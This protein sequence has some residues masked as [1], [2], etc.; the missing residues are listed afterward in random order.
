METTL[1]DDADLPARRGPGRPRDPELADRV[2][3]VVLDLYG[4]QGW[5]GLTIGAV[6]S[7]AR[8]GRSSLY[9]RWPD[10]ESL[11][12][13]ALEDREVTFSEVAADTSVREVL[14]H[15]AMR[16]ANSYL[17]RFGLAFIRL[18]A[19]ARA[20]QGATNEVRRQTFARNVLEQRRNLEKAIARGDLD[21]H[22]PVTQLLDALEGAILMHI[23]A[24]PPELE[25]TVRMRLP[26]YLVDLVDTLLAPWVPT[27]AT[28]PGAVLGS[29]S[30]FADRT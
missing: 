5:A 12:T 7:Q 9:L 13:A 1:P 27:G 20:L 8:V 21:P 18:H 30:R 25:E 23:L 22:T 3:E 14:V 4:R 28:P 29:G 2:F 11:L 16:R 15:H 19:E 6:A 24:T 17:G 26:T 10:K